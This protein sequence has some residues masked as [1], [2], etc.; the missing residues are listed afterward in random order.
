MGV[1]AIRRGHVLLPRSIPAT[2]HRDTGVALTELSL[3]APA[4]VP[5]L[6]GRTHAYGG[7]VVRNTSV[8]IA[9][10]L[11]LGLITTA[12]DARCWGWQS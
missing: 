5:I 11:L 3:T 2:D 12:A 1:S 9:S 8:F 4:H 10:T 7:N 6:R